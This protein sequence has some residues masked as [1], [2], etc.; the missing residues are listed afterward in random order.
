MSWILFL[1]D[2]VLYLART[3]LVS[4]TVAAQNL[5]TACTMECRKAVV[6]LG[7]PVGLDVVMDKY[8]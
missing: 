5:Q 4:Y 7:Y 1:S 2:W 3:W 6:I 8:K